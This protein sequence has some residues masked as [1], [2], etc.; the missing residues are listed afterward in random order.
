[1]GGGVS[2]EISGYPRPDTDQMI[3]FK[4]KL[5]TAASYHPVPGGFFSSCLQIMLY[6]LNVVFP[7]IMLLSFTA[8]SGSRVVPFRFTRIFKLEMKV[9]WPQK[10]IAHIYRCFPSSSTSCSVNANVATTLVIQWP[11]C[12][13]R[14][15]YGKPVE[16]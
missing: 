10:L 3:P 15:S 1:M 8:N 9:Q 6:K 12:F 14:S 11:F 7:L 16:I 4:P 2:L 13:N 5:N